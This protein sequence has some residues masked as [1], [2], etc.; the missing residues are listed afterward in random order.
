MSTSTLHLGI[1]YMPQ[2]Y[3]MGPTALLPL[4]RKACWGFFR[5]LKIRRLRPGLNPRTWVLK[6][7]TLPLDHRSR[8][9]LISFQNRTWWFPR[10]LNAYGSCCNWYAW[11]WSHAK[12]CENSIHLVRRCLAREIVKIKHLTFRGPCSVIY[13]YN[14]SQRDALFLNFILV[15]SGRNWVP[16]WPR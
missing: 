1:F 6:A 2:I 16:T 8:Y 4:R 7:S 12:L 3:D 9:V 15:R 14:K 5:P 13:S 11:T 10:I